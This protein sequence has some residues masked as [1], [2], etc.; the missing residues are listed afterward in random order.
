MPRKAQPVL[1]LNFGSHSFSGGGSGP[2]KTAGS[3]LK[4]AER[5]GPSVSAVYVTGIAF[6]ISASGLG[7]QF[8]SLSKTQRAPS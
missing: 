8:S 6:V 1:I 3:V 5:I 7:M 4:I 2:R